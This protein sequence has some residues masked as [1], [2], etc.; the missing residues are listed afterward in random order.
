MLL[1]SQA[2]IDVGVFN[3]TF[4]FWYGDRSTKQTAQIYRET[5]EAGIQESAQRTDQ[6]C[7]AGSL[8]TEACVPTSGSGALGT[9]SSCIAVHGGWRCNTNDMHMEGLHA[10]GIVLTY[11][12]FEE[13]VTRPAALRRGSL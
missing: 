3:H 8:I 9:G 1:P 4:S 5:A 11:A 6:W 10:S 12:V 7:S 13:Q 2:N